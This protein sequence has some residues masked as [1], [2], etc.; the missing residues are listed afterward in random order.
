MIR[1]LLTRTL[2]VSLL[3]VFV[4]NTVPFAP[5]ANASTYAGAIFKVGIIDTGIDSDHPC[6]N[7]NVAGGKNFITGVEGKEAADDNDGHG[8]RVAGLIG[9]EM[10]SDCDPNILGSNPKA[11]MYAL[12]VFETIPDRYLPLSSDAENRVA[13][14]INY[15]AAKDIK[16][17]N[18]SWGSYVS[19]EV[20]KKA[21]A[22]YP[23]ILFVAAAGNSDL[24]EA[25]LEGLPG[26]NRI[27]FFNNNDIKPFYPASYIYPNI[28]SVAG[29]DHRNMLWSNY[30]EI[31]VDIAASGID[32]LSTETGGSFIRGLEG[33]YLSAAF[34]T[35][36][37]S[38]Y[39]GSN[40][41]DVALSVKSKILASTSKTRFM[42]G[43][44][45]TSGILSLGNLLNNNFTS[46]IVE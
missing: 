38:Y 42:V 28:I 18:I 32:V 2:I 7:S 22:K 31:S 8:T 35:S 3:L 17:I 45:S 33:T 13:A 46:V 1:K 10:G 11:E 36:A 40:Q 16:L 19:S 37:A 9:A 34:V 23:G 44:T 12:K 14:A 5:K 41:G 4:V 25:Q 6:L 24:S 21:I 39:W 20:I 26:I 15:A 30:G 29:H 43:V 27:N